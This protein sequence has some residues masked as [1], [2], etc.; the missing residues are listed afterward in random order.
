MRQTG[1]LNARGLS[2]LPP[3]VGDR[4]EACPICKGRGLV[5][6]GTY[7]KSHKVV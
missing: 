1:E 5:R 7:R 2:L 6:K 3:L 4:L